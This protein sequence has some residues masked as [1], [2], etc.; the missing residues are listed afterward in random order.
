MRAQALGPYPPPS[1]K[2]LALWNR[3]GA[4]DER[5]AAEAEARAAVP[6]PL[7]FLTEAEL[8]NPSLLRVPAA[9]GPWA[10]PVRSMTKTT[11]SV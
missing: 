2:Q 6:P 1:L 3:P 8:A 7:R 9:V 10:Q 4:H 5:V 11:A